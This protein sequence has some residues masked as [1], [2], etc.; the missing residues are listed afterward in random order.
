MPFAAKSS[1]ARDTALLQRVI[2]MERARVRLHEE[3]DSLRTTVQTLV[4]S[5]CLCVKVGDE[6]VRAGVIKAIAPDLPDLS[7]VPNVL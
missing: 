4:F 5:I 6:R 2:S 3:L 7:W 1:T